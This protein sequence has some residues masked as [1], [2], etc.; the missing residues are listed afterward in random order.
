MKRKVQT[1]SPKRV[2]CPFRGLDGCKDGNGRGLTPPSF[3]RHLQSFHLSDD[4]A[5]EK[6]HKLLSTDHGM[7]ASFESILKQLGL[8]FCCGC[9]NTHTLSKNCYH[10]DSQ[11]TIEAPASADGFVSF[12]ISGISRPTLDELSTVGNDLVSFDDN[13]SEGIIFDVPLLERVFRVKSNTVKSVPWKCRLGFARVLKEALVKVIAEP[14]NVLAW[15]QL[16]ILPRCILSTFKPKSSAESRSGKRR[17]LQAE[18]ISDSIRIWREPGGIQRLVCLFLSGDHARPIGVSCDDDISLEDLNLKQCKRKLGDGHYTAAIRVLTS[19]GIAPHNETTLRELIAKHP[20][21]P[22]PQIPVDPI[23]E[24]PLN[25]SK[26][27][28]LDRIKSFPK[29]TSCGKDGLRAQHLIDALSGAAI[30]IADDLLSSITA[31][32]NLFLRGQCP[33]SLGEFV[34]SAPLTPLL[35]PGGGVR[36]IAVGSVWRRLV[37]KVAAIVVGKALSSYMEDTQFGVGVSGGGEAILH[38]VNRLVEDQGNDSSLSMLLVDFKNAFNLVDREAMINVV[39]GK[40]PSISRWVEFCYANP[41]RLYYGDDVLYSCQGVQQGDPLGPLLFALVLQP[42]THKIR[43]ECTLKLNA[44]YLD[45]GTIIGDTMMVSK[46][47]GIIMEDGPALGL[48]LNVDKTELFWPSED[49]RCRVGGLFPRNISRPTK[50]V[51]LLGGA[52]SLDGDFCS[53][54]ALKR[55]TK[56][57]ELMEAIKKLRDPQCEMLL[58]RACSGVSRLYFSLRTAAPS[59]FKLAQKVFDDALRVTVEDMTNAAGAGFGCW[60]WRQSSM[61]I[62]NGGLGLYTVADTMHFAFVAS[63]LQSAE[64]QNRILMNAEISGMGSVFFDALDIYKK[65]TGDTLIS[66]AVPPAPQLMKTMAGRFYC[67]IEKSFEVDFG[68]SCRQ[69]AL[70]ANLKLP[71]AQQ[72]L[73]TI[74]ISG[75]GQVMNPPTFRSVIRYRLGI[76]QYR[77]G[78]KCPACE[79]GILDAWGDHALACAAD[80]GV[81]H[82]HNVVRDAL[83]DVCLRVGLSVQKEASTGMIDAKGGELRPADILFYSWVQGKDTCVDITGTSPFSIVGL[84]GFI[85][86]K[87]VKTAASNKMKKY[88]NVCDSKGY[89]FLPFSFS[90]IGD[91]GDDATELLKRICTVARGQP[92]G[93]KDTSH[94]LSR[95]AF[96]IQKGCGA[97]LV[98]RLPSN[99]V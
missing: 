20:S 81:K 49:P 25:V 39:R 84:Q 40:C 66:T 89:H 31:V 6:F 61:P 34:A 85:P 17:S 86:G 43:E 53:D 50:G 1:V 60:Q 88:E 65:A 55:V 2:H 68:L 16:L 24:P 74:P 67:A 99:F 79:K 3:I 36:P 72:W 42:L 5:V 77:E 10:E 52:V 51:K 26:S 71:M 91:L 90:T 45:D 8:W 32:V 29:G 54:L 30:A 11:E 80:I 96:S 48:H 93:C 14:S 76:A 9:Y 64:L 70:W 69:K 95:I 83:Y 22:A 59:A 62:S 87:A 28:V 75:L 38:A 33:P 37:S 56:T 63:R 12:F 46:A 98:S 41:A 35:K 18:G 47:L 92:G 13:H 15:V 97:Q 23:D 94:I 58:L 27:L 73:K 19:S 7:F 21:A 44:W 82:R 4:G 57:I 78:S